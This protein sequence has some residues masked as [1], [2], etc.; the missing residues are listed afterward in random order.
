MIELFAYQLIQNYLTDFV[1]EILWM[2]E[3]HGQY[4]DYDDVRPFR[5]LS[6]FIELL[7]RT[8]IITTNKF[9]NKGKLNIKLYITFPRSDNYTIRKKN[10]NE[11]F[12]IYGIKSKIN[13]YMHQ[14]DSSF[15]P[16]NDKYAGKM[17]IESTNYYSLSKSNL[18][19][20]GKILNDKYQI[21]TLTY[22]FE[23]VDASAH[24]D[25]TFVKGWNYNLDYNLDYDIL[26]KNNDI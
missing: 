5:D 4:D 20:N 13:K 11:S 22:S 12:Y 1:P 19:S 14:L 16:K 26:E 6:V 9:I 21:L 2:D 10:I 8:D 24:I 17:L 3:Y 25:T 23:Y 7:K 18:I 15:Y